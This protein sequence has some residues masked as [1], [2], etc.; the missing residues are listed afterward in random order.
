MAA[1]GILN[2]DMGDIEPGIAP[3]V[4]AIATLL[5]MHRDGK[6]KTV[7]RGARMGWF[8]G[9][10]AWRRAKF[11]TE[12]DINEKISQILGGQGIGSRIQG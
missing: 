12:L 10:E 1:N 2:A 5:P 8:E 4:D 6:A 3:L 11:E 9:F 7:Y